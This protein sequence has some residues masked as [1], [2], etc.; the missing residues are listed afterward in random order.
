MNLITPITEQLY[1]Y[2][3]Q[4]DWA[5][6]ITFIMIAY[7]F[8]NSIIK[9]KLYHITRL[10]VSTKYRTLFVGIGYGIVVFFIRDYSVK[11][12]ECLIESFVFALVFHKLL[13]QELIRSIENR[14]EAT[15]SISNDK[16]NHKR[17]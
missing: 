10:K 17:F 1:H 16:N 12:I 6:I 9:L 8:N 5:Y 13:L 7:C 14:S 11:H 2:V 15:N 3:S 4:L